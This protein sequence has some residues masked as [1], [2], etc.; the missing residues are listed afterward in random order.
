MTNRGAGMDG[1]LTPEVLILIAGGTFVLGYLT[2][3]Q[4]ILRLLLLIGTVFYIWYYAIVAAA[5][6]WEAIY[7]SLVMGAANLIGLLSL[8]AQR[9]HLVVPS[10]HRDIYPLFSNLTPG[11]FR[12]LVKRA[13][14]FTTV[15]DFHLATEG[16]ATQH[17]FYI[18]NGSAQVEKL[19][20]QFSL[21]RGTFVGEVA[22]LTGRQSAATTVL[23]AGSEVLQW[24]YDDLRRRS[25]R[26]SRF[27][28]ALEAM[29]ASDLAAKVSFAVAPSNLS[30]VMDARRG[31]S[32]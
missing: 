30:E 21:P 29:I 28:L 12:S 22:F 24:G 13:E 19:G 27:K 18:I 4:V 20:A 16:E 6:L 31:V 1:L 5:P 25:T 26:S 32:A 15:E 11:D 17:L 3:N 10:K 2:I 9:S 7:T 14:R 23:A 8:L